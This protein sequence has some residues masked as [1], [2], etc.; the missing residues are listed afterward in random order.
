MKKKLITILSLVIM[1]FSVFGLTGCSFFN[2]WFKPTLDS[3][4]ITLNSDDKKITWQ[5]VENATEYDV[6]INEECVDTVLN[7]D[8]ENYYVFA[9]II[10]EETK[11]Y[12][13]YI[14]AK[15]D[16]YYDSKK[17]NAVTYIIGTSTQSALQNVK[18]DNSILSFITNVK[19]ENNIVT[20]DTKENQDIYYVF[21]YSNTVGE[22]LFE[23]K[24]NAFDYSS[25]VSDDE[26]VMLRVGV[27]DSN[28]TLIL[29]DVVYANTCN[30]QPTY[31]S[32]YFFV[33]GYLG[34]YYITDQSELNKLAYY[35]FINRMAEV[36]VYFASDYLQNLANRYG[37]KEHIHLTTA[38]NNACASFTETCDYDRSLAGLSSLNPYKNDIT[39]KFI[40]ACTEPTEKLSA[41]RTQNIL[42]TPYYETV[43]YE[44]RSAD[45]DNFATDNKPLIQYVTTGEQLY[46]AIESGVTPMFL[47]TDCSAYKLY[48]KAKDVL[49]TIISDQ[50]SDY[51]KVLSI[52][53][54]ISYNSVYDDN[55]VNRDS[56]AE[57]SFTAFT[58][59]YLEGVLYDGLSVCDGF[60]KTFSLL[61]NMES[62]DAVRI[63]GEVKGGL[64]AWNKVKLNGNWYIVDITWTVTKTDASDFK[65]GGEAVN[66][67][68]K[69]FL[70]YKYFLVSDAFVSTTHTASDRDRNESMPAYNEYYFYAVSTYDGLHNRIISSDEEFED[71]VNYMLQHKQYGIEVAFDEKYITLALDRYATLHNA[72]MSSACKKAKTAC[73][74]PD[75]NILLVGTTVRQ[76]SANTKGSIYNIN[77]INLPESVK[78]IGTQSLAA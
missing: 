78:N 55:I 62:I 12:K 4:T 67:N 28:A 65:D 51:E 47:T 8:T 23:T 27:M 37:T 64:H 31:N 17:S 18:V 46:H 69:E 53:D 49:R 50:M 45:Y 76:V 71:L 3:P 59:F 43:N 15:A 14:I 42:D 66:F 6:Y 25:Y 41:V 20:W 7:S 1:L 73:G 63:T 13:I 9:S 38:V 75:G 16:K 30:V 48:S 33:D 24:I 22:Q 57:P 2:N 60:S 68:S 35:M 54:Y 61:C 77:L 58:S 21:M 34:D 56:K 19:V 70:S 11:L 74:F 44:K 39:I 10:K 32:Q 29:S 36:K 5:T 40:F 26:V 72:E 52:F